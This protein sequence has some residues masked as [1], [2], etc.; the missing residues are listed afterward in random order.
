MA[1][2]KSKNT[3]EGWFAA[4]VHCIVYTASVCVFMLNF[5]LIWI[6]VVFLSHFPIDKFGLADVYMKYITGGDMKTY[7]DRVNGLHGGLYLHNSRGIETLTGSFTT[8]RYLIIDNGLHILI[9]WGAY[10][11]IY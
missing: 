1:L 2:N 7:V 6:A 3:L 11:I 4:F 5:D 10:Q 8:L 9:M